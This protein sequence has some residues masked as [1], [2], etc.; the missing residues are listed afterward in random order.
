LDSD[1]SSALAWSTERC[2]VS[3]EQYNI[4]MLRLLFWQVDAMS[5]TNCNFTLGTGS[6]G[7]AIYTQVR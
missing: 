4:P 6:K 5:V 1:I 3:H 7:G 2:T